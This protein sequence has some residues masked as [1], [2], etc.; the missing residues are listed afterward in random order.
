[1]LDAAPRALWNIAEQLLGKSTVVWPAGHNKEGFA[2]GPCF[3]CDDA[4][5][6]L[7]SHLGVVV[8]SYLTK[9]S[10][11]TEPALRLPRT[12]PV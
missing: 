5:G 1:M 3:M 8:E 9:D 10:F 4:V 11:T 12:G 6:G 2:T 7:G